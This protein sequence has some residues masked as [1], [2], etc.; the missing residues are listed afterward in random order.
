LS[1]CSIINAVRASSLTPLSLNDDNTP[2]NALMPVTQSV[3]LFQFQ[4]EEEEE[5]KI[6]SKHE[7]STNVLATIDVADVRQRKS[8]Q[9]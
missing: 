2:M 1:F 6:E 8:T 9:C 3:I 5:E 4:K 7:S